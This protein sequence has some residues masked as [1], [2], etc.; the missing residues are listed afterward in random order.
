MDST[1][2][3]AIVVGAGPVGR[4]LALAASAKGQRILVLEARAATDAIDDDR[5]LALSHGSWLMLE[6]LGAAA[7]LAPVSTSIDRIHIS[8]TGGP[9]RTEL[10][11]ADN[12]LPALGHVV[13]YRDL[14]A[15]LAE[16][17][18][19]GATIRRGTAVTQVTET[20]D[21]ATVHAGARSF[22]APTVIIAEGGGA[23]LATLG[24]GQDTK[25]YGVSALVAQVTTDRPHRNVAYERFAAQG[26]LALLPRGSSY[27][28]VWTLDPEQAQRAVALPPVAFLHELQQAFGWRAGRFM[29][30]ADRRTF[31]L[32]LRR[33]SNGPFTR[34]AVLGNAA[35]TLHPVAGQGLNLGL[36]DAWTAARM[37]AQDG[38]VDATAFSRSRRRDRGVSVGFTD[39]LAELFTTSAPGLGVAR[40]VGLTTLDVAPG[41]RRLFT[42]ALSIGSMR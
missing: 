7:P 22:S 34:V 24:Y 6:R 29:Q 31:P 5:T 26:P 25:D 21:A 41:L 33:T 17:L 40:G 35:Q 18:A 4:F 15:A 20:A 36:R 42:R 37:L 9:G 38:S 11:A 30:V 10:C 2:Y 8:Q 1:G 19:D 23:L 14:Q 12:D 32:L 27:A 16:A 28:L 13:G 3:D 39:L